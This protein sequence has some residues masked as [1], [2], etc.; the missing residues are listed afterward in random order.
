[1]ITRNVSGTECA[2]AG[3]ITEELPKQCSHADVATLE[4]SEISDR[5]TD[6]YV[7]SAF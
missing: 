1:M 6:A 7:F 4:E 3:D 2:D 5:C